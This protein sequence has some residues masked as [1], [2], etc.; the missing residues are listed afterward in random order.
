MMSR[1]DFTNT[2]VAVAGGSITCHTVGA[3]VGVVIVHGAMQ[4]GASQ[5][6]LAEL[7]A[8]GYSVHLVDRRGRG[9]STAPLVADPGV[10]LDDLQAVVEATGSRRIIGVSSGAILAARLALRIP[11]LERLILFE[12]P[13]S[14][15]DSMGLARTAAFDAAIAAGDVGRAMAVAMKIAEMG[16]PWMF[17]LPIPL[18]AVMSRRMLTPERKPVAR[19]LEADVAIIRA[20]AERVGDFAAI[21]TPTLVLDGTATRPYLR[22]A[23]AALTAVIPG[24]RQVSLE[25]LFHAATQNRDEFGSPDAV[26]PTLLD[27]LT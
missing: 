5:A 16:P 10:E 15:D 1:T 27:F 25:G 22:K 8:P 7:L 12:P 13:L 24:A 26:A 17:G 21:T 9:S 18:L 23:A 14:I 19:G 6:D 2:Q 20:S 11:A 3:G 4:D